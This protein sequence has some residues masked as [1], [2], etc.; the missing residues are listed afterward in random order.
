MFVKPNNP[1]AHI[2][3]SFRNE[4]QQTEAILNRASDIRWPN[5][6]HNRMRKTE[7]GQMVGCSE[8]LDLFQQ[9]PNGSPI[10]SPAFYAALAKASEASG[11]KIRWG[12]TFKKNIGGQ[13]LPRPD[14]PHFEMIIDEG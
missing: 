3:D 11:W 8:A 14:N 1:T 13:I 4:Q 12:G 6:R 7:T 5:S 2:S 9:L 10:W